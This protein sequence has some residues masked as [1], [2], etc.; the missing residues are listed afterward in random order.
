MLKVT[1]MPIDGLGM[2]SKLKNGGKQQAIRMGRVQ[3]SGRMPMFRLLGNQKDKL[4][5]LR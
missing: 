1:N 4:V 2:T 3:R 5:D